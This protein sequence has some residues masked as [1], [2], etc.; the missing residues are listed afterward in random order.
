[1]FCASFSIYVP[2]ARWALFVLLA[3]ALVACRGERGQVARCLF[4]DEFERRADAVPN[5]QGPASRPASH[6]MYRLELRRASS[7]ALPG[8]FGVA[9]QLF[10]SQYR[11]RPSR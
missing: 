3:G 10:S 1:M 7:Y 9:F 2:L 8:G 5:L 11:T 4:Y 6:V